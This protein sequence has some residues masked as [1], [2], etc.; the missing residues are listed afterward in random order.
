MIQMVI[1][2]I[3]IVRSAYKMKYRNALTQALLKESR[4]FQKWAGKGMYSFNSQD[5]EEEFNKEIKSIIKSYD[6]IAGG[7][8]K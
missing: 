8:H 4:K 5:Q 1:Q 2:S 7:D 6:I 3:V